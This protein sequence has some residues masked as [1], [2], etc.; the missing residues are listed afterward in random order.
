MEDQEIDKYINN[1]YIVNREQ[2]L[3]YSKDYYNREGI[4]EKRK[5]YNKQYYN[6]KKKYVVCVK[7]NMTILEHNFH[8]HK[9]SYRHIYGQRK[10]KEEYKKEYKKV[11]IEIVQPKKFL[12]K[13]ELII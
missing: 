8:L 10:K 9:T 13:I 3:Q 2:I 5:E 1:Y 11:H 12:D 4:R 6:S 7:C